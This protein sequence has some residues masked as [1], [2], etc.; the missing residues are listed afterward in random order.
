MQVPDRKTSLQKVRKE[1][2]LYAP[3]CTLLFYQLHSDKKNNLFC[4]H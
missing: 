2:A 1:Y 3:H 4:S